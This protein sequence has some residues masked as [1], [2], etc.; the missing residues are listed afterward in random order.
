MRGKPNPKKLCNHCKKEKPISAFYKQ[1]DKRGHKLRYHHNICRECK[2]QR[3]KNYYI[4]NPNKV[5]RDYKE[6]QKNY[7]KTIKG[8]FYDYRKKSKYRG[9]SFTFTFSQFQKLLNLPC[10]YCGS[11]K[12]IGLDRVD[13]A[14]GYIKGNT[15]PCCSICNIAKNDMPYLAFILHCR[16][17]VE[18][19]NEK[20][21]D[22]I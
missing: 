22:V 12:N 7:Y 3:Q 21:E 2:K 14:K 19:Q 15:L 6:Y 17:I 9:W 11:F 13:S 10:H 20:I 8:K 1:I 4:N 16:R 5:Y 18:C